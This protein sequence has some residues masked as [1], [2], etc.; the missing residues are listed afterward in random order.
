MQVRA[1]IANNA[2]ACIQANSDPE[3]HH[4]TLALGLSLT[5]VIE[6]FK[7][8]LHRESR[9]AGVRFMGVIGER[10]IPERHDRI[11]HIFIDRSMMLHDIVGQ[12]CEKTID[13]SG[14]TLRIVPVRLRDGR[15]ATDIREEYGQ[16]TLLSTE[17]QS[18]GRMRQL[19]DQIRRK[20]LAE[21]R[22]DPMPV[23]RYGHIIRTDQD[24]IDEKTR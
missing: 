22:S 15:E 21:S 12:R 18:L 4:Q 24:R 2:D 16:L 23:R 10:S 5:L 3:R 20:I 19:L 9:L 7:A 11:A 14:Q 1:E 17:G 6:R 13:E 8:I